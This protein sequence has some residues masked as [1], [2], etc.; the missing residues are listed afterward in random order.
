VFYYDNVYISHWNQFDYYEVIYNIMSGY[1]Q[2][3]LL[4]RCLQKLN[5]E[6]QI[7]MI[8]KGNKY[9]LQNVKYYI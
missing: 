4:Y 5:E 8:K 1:R 6:E 3:D 7:K 2:Y 9:A